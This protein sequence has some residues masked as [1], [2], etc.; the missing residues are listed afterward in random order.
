MGFGL[1]AVAS[2]PIRVKQN[3]EQIH[4]FLGE[5]LDAS[6]SKIILRSLF[7]MQH[8]SNRTFCRCRLGLKLDE[9]SGVTYLVEVYLPNSEPMFCSIVGGSGCLIRFLQISGSNKLD[10]L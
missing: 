3:S 1:S 6:Q 4:F 7:F 2:V 8:Q 10:E 5:V 9:P